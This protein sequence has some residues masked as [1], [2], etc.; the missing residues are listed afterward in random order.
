MSFRV[1][2]PRCLHCLHSGASYYLE[3][4]VRSRGF[5][6]PEYSLLPEFGVNMGEGGNV[7]SRAWFRPVLD[8]PQHLLSEIPLVM[9]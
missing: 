5:L 8:P 4:L 6:D 2:G 7:M 9:G 3:A 1:P